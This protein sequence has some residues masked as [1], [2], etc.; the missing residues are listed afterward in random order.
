MYTK[1]DNY[2]SLLDAV[3][4]DKQVDGLDSSTYKRYPIRFVLFDNFKDSYQFIMTLIQ[5]QSPSFKSVQDWIDSDYPDL[6][7]KHHRLA[8][9]IE[10]YIKSLNGNDAVITPFS[11]LARFYDN[12]K[13][14]EFDTLINTLK[15]I[16]TEEEGWENQQRIYLPIV[17]LEGKMSSFYDDCQTIIWYLP[18]QE[19][20]E[21][22]RLISTFG[23]DYGVKNLAAQYTIKETMSEWLDYWRVP[24]EDHKRNIICTSKAIHANAEFAQPDNAFVYCVC[25]NVY[26]FL[27]RGLNLKMTGLEYRAQDEE[28]WIRLAQ[29]IDLKTKFDFDDFFAKYFSVISIDSYKTFIKLWFEHNDGFSRW[30]LTNTLKRSCD[31]THFLRR[32]ITKTSDFT[33]RDLFSCIALELPTNS[34]D[35]E[36]RRFCLTEAAGRKVVLPDDVQHKMISKLEEIAQQSGY[37]YA[38][39]LFTPIS[40]KE[41]ELAVICLGEDKISRDDIKSFYPEL[42]HYMDPAIGTIDSSQTWILSYIDHYK[43]AKIADK[44]TTEIDADIKKYNANEVEFLKWKNCFKTTRSN[45]AS[46]SDIDVFYWID[47]LGIDWIPLISYLIS[48]R[49]NDKVY[50]NDVKI[51]RALLPTIT[52]VNKQDLEKLQSERTEFAKVGNIDEMA[53]KNTNTYPSNIVAELEKVKDVINDILNL[54]AGKKI[55]IISDHGLTY[56]SQKQ[57]GL[58]LKG[59][60]Y[61]HS[62][63]YAIR[64]SGIA[65]KDEN[66][67]LLESKHVACALNHKSLGAKIQ[68]GLGAHGG[69]T[70]EEVLV[71]IFIISSCANSKTWN[72]KFLQDEISGTDPVIHLMITGLSSLDCIRIQYAG[73]DYNVRHIGGNL[74]DSDPI[75][76]KDGDEEFMLWV[77][78]V[79]E[80]KKLAV[81]TGTKEDDLFADFGL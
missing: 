73:K 15:T 11:E 32:I 3:R 38:A 30:L 43:K 9:E 7:I 72:A 46:R 19:E 13:H 54:Y 55:A 62:G 80:Q 70:P 44:Y 50:L 16:E 37:S 2:S 31:E 41:K 49:A 14:K 23:T 8:T 20:D 29:E 26:D 22:Y 24:D 67:H 53:H 69:C 77:G 27:T 74:F 25:E 51:A 75:D 10:K 56:L 33:S 39:Q 61:H 79:G 52:E 40:V 6:M 59:F 21:G 5:E 18:S 28:Y 76:L 63:R 64:T 12:N 78:D 45:M 65:T 36:I 42:Y 58:K 47:G 35:I 48:E 66:Y 34:V 1:F 71:P 17:G 60:D 81:N 68:S 4:K 57:P